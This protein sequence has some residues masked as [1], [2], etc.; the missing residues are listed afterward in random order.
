M[1]DL[2]LIAAIEGC[3]GAWRLRMLKEYTGFDGVGLAG[4]SRHTYGRL[5]CE[6][7]IL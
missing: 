4:L 5:A 1:F 3:S 7:D 2:Y 6:A